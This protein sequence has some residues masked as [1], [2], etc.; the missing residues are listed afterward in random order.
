MGSEM[1]IRDR[2]YKD[3]QVCLGQ[4]TYHPFCW[5]PCQSYQYVIHLY[6]SYCSSKPFYRCHD[7][8]LYLFIFRHKKEGEVLPSPTRNNKGISMHDRFPLTLY[9]YL[10]KNL[11][12]VGY[13]LNKKKCLV[14]IY[15]PRFNLKR[16]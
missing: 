10:I 3:L 9:N 1:C 7:K 16:I 15:S 11:Y 8:R 4:A 13:L 6:Y 14:P 2:K 12:L 5:Q